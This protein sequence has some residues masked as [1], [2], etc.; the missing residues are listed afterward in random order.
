MF[1]TSE[2]PRFDARQGQNMFKVSHLQRTC[3]ESPPTRSGAGIFGSYLTSLK[4]DDSDGV[5][6]DVDVDFGVVVVVVV[7][8]VLSSASMSSSLREKCDKSGAGICFRRR[9]LTF[10]RFD[11]SDGS[12][13]IRR[14]PMIRWGGLGLESFLTS[15]EI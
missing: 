3:S 13:V 1:P 4:S 9:T 6:N 7:D 12:G 2:G 15:G 8:T 14:S 11:P 10:F 5:L